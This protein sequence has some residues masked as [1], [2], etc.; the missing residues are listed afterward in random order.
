MCI[1]SRLSKQFSVLLHAVRLKDKLL[2]FAMQVI[3]KDSGHLHEK[4]SSLFDSF[5]ALCLQPVNA[6]I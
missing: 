3:D 5:E 1:N 4:P 6:T 2:C